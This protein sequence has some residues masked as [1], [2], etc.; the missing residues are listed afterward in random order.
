MQLGRA[1]AYAVLAVIAIAACAGG[2]NGVSAPATAR[3]IARRQGIPVE[4]LRKILQRLKSAR[5][6]RSQRGRAGGFRLSRPLSRITL[7]DVVEAI[8]GRVH[9]HDGL[10]DGAARSAFTHERRNLQR[11]NHRTAGRFRELL[12]KTC[13]AE[14]CDG[15]RS[16]G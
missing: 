7:L 14:L 10:F 3:Q 5:I 16:R 1:A 6:V 11:W 4:Y 13:L 15:A 8:D 12:E 2:G 9:E